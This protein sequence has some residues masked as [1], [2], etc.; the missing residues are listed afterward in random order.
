MSLRQCVSSSVILD[1]FSNAYSLA[2]S[3]RLDIFEYV[4]TADWDYGNLAIK[5]LRS[6][7]AVKVVKLNTRSDHMPDPNTFEQIGQS[8]RLLHISS[9]SVG[10]RYNTNAL[11]DLCTT[12][13]NLEVL[14]LDLVDIGR[15]VPDTIGAHDLELTTQNHELAVQNETA[16][17]QPALEDSLV[18]M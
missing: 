3:R 11:R 6:L 13:P 18:R 16:E 5:F 14:C 8:I 10:V 2:D 1:A 4:A 12:F 9:S 7:E 17:L 15:D